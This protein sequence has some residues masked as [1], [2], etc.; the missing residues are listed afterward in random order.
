MRWSIA[1]PACLTDS[2]IVGAPCV[3]QLAN[4]QSTTPVGTMKPCVLSVAKVALR[5]GQQHL[6]DCLA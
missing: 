1:S 4:L 2:V 5:S 3:C 6:S